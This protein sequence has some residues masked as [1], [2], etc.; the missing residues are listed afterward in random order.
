[1]GNLILKHFNLEITRKCNQK[2]FYCFND[3]GY[4]RLQNELKLEEWEKTLTSLSDLGVESVHITGG[5]PFLHPNIIR[6][7]CKSVELGLSTTVLSNGFKV[8]S[9][10]Y[11]MPNLFKQ[12]RLAQI[13][14]DSMDPQ[15]HNQRRGFRTAFDDAMAAI[16]ALGQLRVPIEISTTVSDDNLD[17]VL[18]IGNFCKEIGASLIVR[19]LI[20]AGRAS[21][22][23][24]S[25]VFRRRLRLVLLHLV[26]VL[27]VR[28][29]SDRFMYVADSRESDL[30]MREHG[31]VTVEATG[32]IRSGVTPLRT[33][34]SI[35]EEL[36]VA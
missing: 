22:I 10:C 19:P 2:C 5:E 21:N 14:L 28:V 34:D 4:S 25:F 15:V 24:H 3:S 36:R 35:L 12:L 9:Y 8:A 32:R 23:R 16:E 20:S 7:L 31:I 33:I 29:L 1:M 26:D 6:I 27:K 13:S 18:K 11:E 30:I 17:G